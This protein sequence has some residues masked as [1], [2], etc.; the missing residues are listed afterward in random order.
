MR[1]EALRPQFNLMTVAVC[2]YVPS[3]V[4]TYSY[5]LFDQWFQCVAVQIL[6]GSLRFNRRFSRLKKQSIGFLLSE[7]DDGC[8]AVA[9]QIQAPARRLHTRLSFKRNNFF[10]SVV[11]HTQEQVIA[12]LSVM[13]RVPNR[14]LLCPGSLQ[15]LLVVV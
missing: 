10:E 2:V 1:G 3:S 8:V 13:T 4:A 9:T 14:I 11:S 7:L 12:E 6:L 15:P 5:C